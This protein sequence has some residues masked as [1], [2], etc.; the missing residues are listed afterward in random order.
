MFFSPSNSDPIDLGVCLGVN[1]GLWESKMGWGCVRLLLWSSMLL[2]GSLFV[3][4]R[5]GDWK[6][7]CA[8]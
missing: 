6:V 3:N 7:L 8:W 2:S 1:G 4:V 5:F